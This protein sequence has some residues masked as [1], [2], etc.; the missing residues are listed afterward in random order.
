MALE[1]WQE[2]TAYQI[3]PRSF[4]DSNGDG[5]GDLP[6]IISRVDYLDYLGIDMVWLSPIFAS[7]N[8]DYGYDVSNY[9]Q[10]MSEFGTMEDFE[11]LRDELHARDIRLI[12][13][14][15]VNHTSSE[16]EWFKK[17][18]Q[19]PEG[20]YGDFYHWRSGKRNS[21][22][23]NWEAFFGGP[24]WE[25]DEQRREYYLHL[26]HPDQPDL[27]WSNPRVREEIFAV[28]KFWLEKGVD[29][30]RL[31]VINL[32][33]K[34]FDYDTG[35]IDSS[36]ELID[37]T[38][39]VANGSDL[40]E[41]LGEMKAQVFDNYNMVAIGE[42]VDTDE[43]EAQELVA[44]GESPL[45]MLLHFEHVTLDQEESK[46][47]PKSFSLVEFK[48]VI[49]RWYR[50]LY[51]N[52][53]NAYYLTSHDQP[54][55][56]NRFADPDNYWYRSATMLAALLMTLPGTPF[57]YQGDEIGMTNLDFAG[58]EEVRDVESLNLL[59]KMT[60]AG[61]STEEI[62]QLI[63]QRGR[64]NSRS[65]MQWNSQ[66]QAGF[67]TGEPWIK[68]NENFNQINVAR[69]RGKADSILEF[70]RRLNRLRDEFPVLKDGFFLQSIADDEDLFVYWRRNQTTTLL[71]LLNF[72]AEQQR[73][74]D[75][76]FSHKLQFIL[77]NVLSKE[78]HPEQEFPALS[79]YEARIYRQT[80]R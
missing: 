61:S 10:I 29:G 8:A 37:C 56:I 34:N 27:N 76:E 55:A 67:T 54:R 31:D 62:L 12:L 17:S 72:S 28:M 66:A 79:P 4:Q 74:L 13:D 25:W 18:R 16:H 58:V 36:G 68:V 22:P 57:I 42:V 33:S 73:F 7:P 32:L 51:R 69:Q 40:Q 77:G 20:P 47:Q 9:R 35:N 38:P 80:G 14:M 49:D 3:Y 21:P 64:D 2:A 11:E 39:Y 45:D 24:A 5:I 53:W 43:K 75:D 78:E 65:P 41:Y 63:G 19:D 59:E 60:S 26:F 30:F 70:Y 15:V 46:W 6:G 50:S 52:G 23:N 48:E 1:W 71:I 44:G